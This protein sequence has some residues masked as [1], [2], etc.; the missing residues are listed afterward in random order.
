[1]SIDVAIPGDRNEIKK[2]SEKI[3]KYKDRI[4]ETQC[5]LECESKSGN[6]NNRG[7]WNYFK[8][9]QTVREQRTGKARN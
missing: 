4:I 3:L 6:G 8:V 9:S 7:D 2:E 1:M 5:M